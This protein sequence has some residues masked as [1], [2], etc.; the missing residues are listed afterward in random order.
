NSGTLNIDKFENSG[1][2]TASN[3]DKGIY[4]QGNANIQSF[5]NSGLIS[6]GNGVT[7]AGT[8]KNF[9]N[10][11]T[12]LGNSSN[13]ISINSTIENFTNKGTI[14]STGREEPS[15]YGASSGISLS[16]NTITNFN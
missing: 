9:T 14:N 8:I 1:T 4:F 12:I 6:G 7:T 15:A 13:G 2:I 10:N 5:T 3:N 11:G 16:Y